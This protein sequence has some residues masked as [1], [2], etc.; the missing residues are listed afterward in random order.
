MLLPLKKCRLAGDFVNAVGIFKKRNKET[1]L[2]VFEHGESWEV[3]GEEGVNINKLDK[4][5][6]IFNTNR[7]GLC[8]LRGG[9]HQQTARRAILGKRLCR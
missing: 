4:G 1:F 6:I 5:C 8:R 7:E 2:K 3:I 9:C